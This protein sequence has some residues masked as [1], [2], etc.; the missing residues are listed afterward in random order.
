MLENEKCSNGEQYTQATCPYCDY[1]SDKYTSNTT[2]TLLHL[3]NILVVQLRRS[4][5]DTSRKT[6]ESDETEINYEKYLILHEGDIE[7]QYELICLITHIGEA[8]FGH[9]LAFVV[10]PQNQWWL[11]EDYLLLWM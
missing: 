7:V 6:M 10:D 9:Y 2:V 11:L 8:T 1:T 3:P 5:Y 4:Y